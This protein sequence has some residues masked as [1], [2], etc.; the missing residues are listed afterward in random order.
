MDAWRA[1]R[2]LHEAI[3]AVWLIRESGGELEAPWAFLWAALN[4]AN[5]YPLPEGV[6]SRW[7][8][9]KGPWLAVAKARNK[10]RE[11]KA[12]KAEAK[13]SADYPMNLDRPLVR[14]LSEKAKA[15]GW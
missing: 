15:E 7:S 14:V 9:I 12:A 1:S 13:A 8:E 4:R 3:A 11:A 6:A 10:K 5:K 2:P